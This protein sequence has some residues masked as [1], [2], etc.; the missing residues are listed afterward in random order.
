MR[1]YLFAKIE[2]M[3]GNYNQYGNWELG[4]FGKILAIIALCLAGGM[5]AYGAPQSAK[6][7]S[8]D[9]QISGELGERLEVERVIDGDSLVLD[10]GL[11][12]SLAGIQ[13]PK[14]AW[15]EKG[16]EAWPL[17]VEAKTYLR[18]LV[19]GKTLQLYYNG[20]QRDRYGRAIA[21]VWI[22]STNQWLQEEMVRAGYARVY[23]QSG[24]SM[25]TR[26]L[27][28]A[29]ERARAK[30]LG[31]WDDANTNNYYAVRRPDPN[32]LAQYVDSVQIVEGIV[33]SAANVR[34]TIYL[35]FGSDYKTDFT[36][37][38]SKKNA[39]KFAKQGFDPLALEGAKIRVRGYIEITNGPIIW[40]SDLWRLEV[41]D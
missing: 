1:I 20:D 15:P 17:A 38:I 4:G 39:R 14:M 10:G 32:P 26:R 30:K 2:Y 13:T 31:I 34:G 8:P 29:E 25:D 6:I 5:P 27:Y 41:L 7:I 3:Y 9:I 36:V 40:L 19:K 22:A 24:H 12:V 35:N 16:Y 33:I 37:A 28:K 11:R 21:Q 18:S 23:S